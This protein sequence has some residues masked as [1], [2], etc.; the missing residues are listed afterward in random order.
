[1]SLF[2]SYAARVPDNTVVVCCVMPEHDGFCYMK[3]SCGLAG[4][5]FWLTQTKGGLPPLP[6]IP[7]WKR[8]PLTA[9]T[10]KE[11]PLVLKGTNQAILKRS[12]FDRAVWERDAK[13]QIYSDIQYASLI[14][15]QIVFVTC[16]EYN[17]YYHT[18]PYHEI[19]INE[20]TN[21]V[22]FLSTKNLLNELKEK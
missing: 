12:N 14:S 16:A 8:R 10:V 15:N 1:M 20:C 21:S 5:L 6:F 9:A 22:F 3:G 19:L 11:F 4:C 7:L 17:R 18:T 2:F 13:G